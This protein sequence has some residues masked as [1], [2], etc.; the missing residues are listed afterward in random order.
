MMLK[1]SLW[2][3][4]RGLLGVE[5]PKDASKG[6]RPWAL[7][8]GRVPFPRLSSLE[9]QREPYQRRRQRAGPYLSPVSPFVWFPSVMSL[10]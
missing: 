3:V 2:Q 5:G 6:Q 10:L 8:L 4:Q 9:E 1:T 7:R